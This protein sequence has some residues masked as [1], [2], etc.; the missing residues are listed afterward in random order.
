MVPEE[1]FLSS[2][3]PG[4][5][6]FPAHAVLRI[7]KVYPGGPPAHLGRL[8]NRFALHRPCSPFQEEWWNR[9]T[10]DSSLNSENNPETDSQMEWFQMFVSNHHMVNFVRLYAPMS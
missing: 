7:L 8:L 10:L 9:T 6:G 3:A 5:E 2:P 1:N 4:E